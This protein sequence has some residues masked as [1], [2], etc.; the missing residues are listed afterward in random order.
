MTY[1]PDLG[2]DVRNAAAAALLELMLA[3]SQEQHY[4]GWLSGLEFSLWSGPP[5]MFDTE[6]QLKL[7]RLLAE[8]SGVWFHW[9][10][11]KGVEEIALADWLA[12]VEQ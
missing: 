11:G 5:S 12:L 10:E 7:L 9:V 6:R 8:E 4:A 1:E 2:S 3:I